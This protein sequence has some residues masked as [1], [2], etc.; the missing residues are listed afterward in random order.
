MGKVTVQQPDTENT[1]VPDTGMP[2]TSRPDADLPDG[3]LPG[4]VH[5]WVMVLG[6]LIV[7][8]SYF[9]IYLIYRSMDPESFLR[10]QQHLD[11]NIGSIN[12]VV[13]LTSSLFVA[14]SVLSAR[15][16]AH[17]Q[18]IGFVYAAGGCGMLF[19]VLKGYE[20]AAKISAGHTN[21]DMFFS[22]YYVI[23]GVHL[24]HVLIGLI[25]LGVVVRELQNPG[26]RRTWMVET[27]AT[28]WHMVD[29]LWVIIFGLLY[30][31]R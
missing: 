28:Y 19:M 7:F 13:L 18:A 3:R 14:R 15:A 26:R 22:F 5:M 30:V 16:G 31:M 12:T 6:D 23:T 29:L 27:G 11:I 2:D 9:L 4:D 17:R 25:V 20:W 24:V 21:S 8:S 10:A 1:E